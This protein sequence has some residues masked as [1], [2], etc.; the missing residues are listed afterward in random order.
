MKV[1][2]PACQACGVRA[3]ICERS[4]GECCDLCTHGEIVGQTQIDVTSLPQ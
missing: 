3:G 2:D 4:A 1:G